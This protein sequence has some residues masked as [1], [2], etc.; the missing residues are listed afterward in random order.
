MSSYILSSRSK[1]PLA[2]AYE[3]T[4]F[5]I[6]S[7]HSE[8]WGFSYI[9]RVV[10][11]IQPTGLSIAL[12]EPVPRLEINKLDMAGRSPLFWAALRGDDLA[13]KTLLQ[14]RADVR[15]QD[16]EGRT[17][18]H[19]AIQAGS[20][21]SIKLPLMAGAS[22]H[23]RDKH[24]DTAIQ[25]AT[26]CH[27][28]CLPDSNVPILEALYLAGAAVNARQYKGNLAIQ[29]AACL[30]HAAHGAYLLSTGA[31][32]NNR[33]NTGDMP[34]CECLF[35]NTHGMICY[36]DAPDTKLDNINNAGQTM[37]HF[38]ALY[39]DVQSM[40]MLTSSRICELSLD[41]RD[42]QGRTARETFEDWTFT[43]DDQLRVA[44]NALLEKA[45]RE[46]D[47]QGEVDMVQT[48]DG[49]SRSVLT[50]S[51]GNEDDALS[52]NRPRAVDELPEVDED[53]EPEEE[54]FVHALEVLNIS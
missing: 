32:P 9:H 4:F 21:R 2:K 46:A 50:S 54:N 51:M 25:I 26:W 35:Y 15:L 42:K 44:F 23:T 1:T 53:E 22:V 47:A 48:D 28:P 5:G 29:S 3:S 27:T 24:G 19:A 39:T 43:Q 38:A 16:Y 40:K 13:V 14:A 34:I 52:P 17:A 41:A 6:S 18:L 33:D 7:S 31:D 36:S 11:G 12:Q 10:V 49:S 20:L 45:S 37:L 8:L 30:S